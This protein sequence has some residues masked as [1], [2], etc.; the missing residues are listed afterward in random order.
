[1]AHIG[2]N[3]GAFVTFLPISRFEFF[4]N[5]HYKRQ[6]IAIGSSA[7]VSAAFGA[8]IGGALFA[9]EISKPNTIWKFSVLWKTFIASAVSVFSL[10]MFQ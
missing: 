1:M 6:M 3:I 9:Y 4:R 8:P 2:A 5:D 7:G 10:A